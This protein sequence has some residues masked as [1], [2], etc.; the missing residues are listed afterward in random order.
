MSCHWFMS[1]A[2]VIIKRGVAYVRPRY[3]V[4]CGFPESLHNGVFHHFVWDVELVCIFDESPARFTSACIPADS[5]VRI[6]VGDDPVP[7]IL[8]LDR[9]R[10]EKEVH[11]GHETLLGTGAAVLDQTFPVTMQDRGQY[12][13]LHSG[14]SS[15]HSLVR[16]ETRVLLS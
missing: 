11:S 10:L 3:E 8:S 4:V 1:G 7:S 13:F 16:L 5:N 6:E 9:D 12:F 2:G 15:A 14:E